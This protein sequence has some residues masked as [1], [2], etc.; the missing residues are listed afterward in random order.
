MHLLSIYAR[1]GGGGAFVGSMMFCSGGERDR[2]R[3]GGTS[4]MDHDPSSHVV[5]RKVFNG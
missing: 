5:T 2:E 1:R 3:E 4:T